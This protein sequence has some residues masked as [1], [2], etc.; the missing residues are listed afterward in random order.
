MCVA[1]LKALGVP[2]LCP[3][4]GVLVQ[5][6]SGRRFS[7]FSDVL[8]QPPSGL[9]DGQHAS[10]NWRPREDVLIC[11]MQEHTGSVNRLAVAPD[12]SF[13]C[14]ASSDRTVKIWQVRG[15]DRRVCPRSAV[16]YTRHGGRVTDV[17]CV[18]NSHG[19]CSASD[20]GQL[21]V[22]RVDGTSSGAGGGS[23]GAWGHTVF[24]QVAQPGSDAVT[25]VQHFTSDIASVIVYCTQVSMPV[26]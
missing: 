25:A 5:P 19:V 17:T 9:G 16:T 23:G 15:I 14:S 22:W 10:V 18:E 24:R 11:S 21:H 20:D 13:F 6:D 1:Q 4:L 8:E 7:V 2:P 26:K 12:Q 3:D